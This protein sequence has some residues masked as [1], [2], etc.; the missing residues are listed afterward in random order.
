M[1][2]QT[3]HAGLA[4][5]QQPPWPRADSPLMVPAIT[6]VTHPATRP[7]PPSRSRPVHHAERRSTR[8]QP[9]GNEGFGV[10]YPAVAGLFAVFLV[11]ALFSSRTVK[12]GA[13]AAGGAMIAAGAARAVLPDRLAGILVSRHR[14]LDAATLAALGLGIVVFGL[15]LPT[16]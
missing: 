12:V 10:I 13:V 5:A 7:D 8:W 14:Y 4:P 3:R 9:G 6:E 15:I 16:P 11:V 1:T 2:P